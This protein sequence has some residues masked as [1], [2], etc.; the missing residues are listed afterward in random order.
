MTDK[1]DSAKAPPETEE[2]AGWRPR[3][4]NEF[5]GWSGLLLL[6]LFLSMATWFRSV[7]D[8]ASLLS[9]DGA[10]SQAVV[11]VLVIVGLFLISAGVLFALTEARTPPLNAPQ[12]MPGGLDQ[13]GETQG[14]TPIPGQLLSAMAKHSAS[15]VLLAL[16]VSLILMAAAA[17]GVVNISVGNQE[18]ADAGTVAPTETPD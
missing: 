7:W 12:A 13:T 3:F 14:V 6:L 1:V 9:G 10:A 2:E 15:R 11:Y 8:S 18:P 4:S 16:G 5:I 17:S